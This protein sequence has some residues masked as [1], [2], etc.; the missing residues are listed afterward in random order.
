MGLTTA[1]FK[2]KDKKYTIYFEKSPKVLCLLYTS[3]VSF[4]QAKPDSL[5]LTCA[6]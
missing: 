2:Q 5:T 4:E 6:Q 3:L 1:S